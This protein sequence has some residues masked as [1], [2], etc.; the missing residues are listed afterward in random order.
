M[1]L[2]DL[3]QYHSMLSEFEF[4][5]NLKK[6]HQLSH[7]GD[8]AAVIPKDSKTDLVITTD[9]LIENIDFKLDWSKPE[10]VGHKALAVSISDI[11]AMGAK[12]VWSLLSIGIPN[13][14]WNSNFVKAFY[15]GYMVL[16]NKCS[17]QLV[18][19]DVSKSPNDIFIDSIVIGE[20]TK[21]KA[22]MRS[23]A[24]AGDSIFVT[25]ELGGASAGLQMLES[26]SRFETST[27][28]WQKSLLLKQL[29]PIPYLGSSLNE[30]ANSMID[31]S[32]GL[33]SDLLHICKSSKLGA[34]IYADKV[35]IDG[36][37]SNFVGA[38][39]KDIRSKNVDILDFALSGGEDF[40]LLFTV[41]QSKIEKFTE[42]FSDKFYHIGEI[43]QDTEN[44]EL[45]VNGESTSLVPNGF[46][47]F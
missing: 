8:D 15:E 12:P 25:G 1:Y 45:I 23:T 5:N 37:I 34:R 11:V 24:K 42:K 6:Q 32:D 26:G 33:S 40:E 2:I 16:A 19:G 30:F 17:V 43:T 29:K 44:I 7:I 38:N 47:H 35:P 3:C 46:V 20:V 21:G 41:S 28:K 13:E 27:D 18:G 36:Y 22:I 4:L 39:S 31:I 9:L 10:F 14:I